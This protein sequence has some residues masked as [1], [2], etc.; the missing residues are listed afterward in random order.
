MITGVQGHFIFMFIKK[1]IRAKASHH[2]SVIAL[3]KGKWVGHS[4]IVERPLKSSGG[5]RAAN[6]HRATNYH[7]KCISYCIARIWNV[8]FIQYLYRYPIISN[9]NDMSASKLA[10]SY[11]IIIKNFDSIHELKQRIAGPHLS[12][13]E[14]WDADG[15]E[16][17]W[18]RRTRH[19]CQC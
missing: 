4:V 15:L 1:D 14:A 16:E 5:G 7:T 2:D 18:G 13:D 11:C 8:Q 3:L 12:S 19:S 6:Q 17:G 9:R 10:F